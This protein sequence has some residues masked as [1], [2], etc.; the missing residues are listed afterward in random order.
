MLGSNEERGK[1]LRSTL[2]VHTHTTTIIVGS[3]EGEDPCRMAISVF[4]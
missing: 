4:I 2:K 3:E 1:V